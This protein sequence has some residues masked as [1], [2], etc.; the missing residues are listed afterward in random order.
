MKMNRAQ[1]KDII[2]ECLVEILT[3]GLGST[4]KLPTLKTTLAPPSAQLSQEA[5][6]R[7][8]GAANTTFGTPKTV[9][10]PQGIVTRDVIKREAGGNS[11]MESIFADTAA[12]TLVEQGSHDNT[13]A[14]CGNFQEHITAEPVDL[15]GAD[16]AE[17]WNAL[18]FMG[19]SKKTA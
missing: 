13:G 9:A 17:R 3:E 19:A 6:Q 7:K 1:L 16:A 8:L 12:T 4:Q 10:K 2:K 14:Q 18:A 5:I 15:F 11:I